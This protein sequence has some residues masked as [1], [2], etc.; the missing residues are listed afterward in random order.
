[1]LKARVFSPPG[2][3]LLFSGTRSLREN[4]TSNSDQPRGGLQC[5]EQPNDFSYTYFGTYF[6]FEILGKCHVN[7]TT[8]NLDIYEIS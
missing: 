6:F 5:H 8:E 4:S 7:I 1:M 2:N 3:P